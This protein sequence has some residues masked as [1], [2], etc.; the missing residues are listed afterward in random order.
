[1]VVES[2]MEGDELAVAIYVQDEGSDC[3]LPGE[4]LLMYAEIVA[5]SIL[6]AGVPA[7]TTT[8]S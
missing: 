4:V 1:M 2:E 3:G 8:G 7:G 6:D 5:V